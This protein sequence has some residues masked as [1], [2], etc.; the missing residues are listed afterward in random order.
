MYDRRKETVSS[1]LSSYHKRAQKISLLRYELSHPS[2]ITGEE[3][4]KAMSY[5]HPEDTRH[6]KGHTT[7]KTPYIALNYQEQAEQMNKETIGQISG[8]LMQLERKQARLEYYVSLLEPRQEQVLRR[9]CFERV[10]QEK[11]AEELGVSV[12][13]G[14]DIKAQAIDELAE[15]YGFTEKLHK[16]DAPSVR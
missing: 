16:E 12:R 11:V 10:P 14:Q 9:T 8:Q 2:H 7:N 13:R 1:L 5:A 15:M 6:I 4:I 3:M